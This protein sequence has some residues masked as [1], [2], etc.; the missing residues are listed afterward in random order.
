MAELMFDRPTILSILPLFLL[1]ENAGQVSRSPG[2][3]LKALLFFFSS[4]FKK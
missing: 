3:N 4:L 2:N 1:I